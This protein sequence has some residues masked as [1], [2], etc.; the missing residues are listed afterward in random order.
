M[1]AEATPSFETSSQFRN[2]LYTEEVLGQIHAA[3]R[4]HALTALQRGGN[5][6]P[7]AF[8]CGASHAGAGACPSA[9]AEPSD[10]AAKQSL[11]TEEEHAVLRRYKQLLLQFCR[12]FAAPD[13]VLATA[14]SFFSRFFLSNSVIVYDPEKIMLG[15]LL[16]AAKVEE[17]KSIT[18]HKIAQKIKTKDSKGEGKVEARRVVESEMLLLVGLRF[19]LLVWH[20][21]SPLLGLTVAWDQHHASTRVAGGGADAGVA[22]GGDATCAYPQGDTLR[23]VRRD[24]HTNVTHAVMH[25]DCCFLFSPADIAVAALSEA[26]AAHAPGAEN[27]FWLFIQERFCAA[28]N[29][30]ALDAL[31]A[32]TRR[33]IERL[34]SV[35][36]RLN[37]AGQD[38]EHQKQKKA[39]KR[40]KKL[41][42]WRQSGGSGT[43]TTPP[44]KKARKAS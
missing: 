40:M 18:A 3:R 17:V 42:A 21:F 9:D 30:E 24:A 13:K 29:V 43:G 6:Q 20:P 22:Q 25:D 8:A 5:L 19:Q 10:D 27:G 1:Q 33:I 34:R 26:V 31:R 2:W 28:G 44:K 7:S 16:L 15:S 11:H 35:A 32:R 36:D 23:A 41:A 14:Q 4:R 37:G 39:V 38:A 12:G